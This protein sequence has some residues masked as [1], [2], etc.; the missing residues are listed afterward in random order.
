MKATVNFT[1]STLDP[2]PHQT[3]R[4]AQD[5]SKRPLKVGLA[6]RPKGPLKIEFAPSNPRNLKP[7]RLPA[8]WRALIAGSL[9]PLTWSVLARSGGAFEGSRRSLP[10]SIVSSRR[11]TF[12]TKV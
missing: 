6:L 9:S 4:A 3:T 2:F 7:Q 1:I 12:H 8:T 10:T 11:P 5:G